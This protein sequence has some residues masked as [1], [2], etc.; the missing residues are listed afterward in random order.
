MTEVRAERFLP[1]FARAPVP[2]V[3]LDQRRRILAVNLAAEEAL[4][5]DQRRALGLT[6]QKMPGF[7]QSYPV[8]RKG[9]GVQVSQL[10]SEDGMR[11]VRLSHI[12]FRLQNRT[13]WLLIGEEL[14]QEKGL[15]ELTTLSHDLLSPLSTIKAYASTLL[16]LE[17]EISPEQKRDYLHS[18]ERVTS[19]L[20][21][22]VQ[23]VLEG[24][25]LE[26]GHFELHLKALSLPRLLRSIVM[27]M[28][29]E[30]P[31]HVIKL[32]KPPAMPLFFVDEKRLEM[33]LTNLITN[34]IKYSPQGSAIEVRLSYLRQKR[35]LR[36][37]ARKAPS[38]PPGPW[39]FIEV[40]DQGAGIPQEYL[41]SI[42]EPFVRASKGRNPA[43]GVG[44]GLYICK[45]IVEAHGG[46]TWARSREGKGSTFSVLL[47][48]QEA[49]DQ[50]V[51]FPSA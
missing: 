12:P 13:F 1:N 32:E 34:A 28:Q 38:L 45:K 20:A 2:L 24:S 37:E 41:E 47:P 21:R 22:L 39:A 42:F 16:K 17:G 5:L 3:V 49:G 25:S 11:K 10:S 43:P 31:H 27:Q 7:L 50:G 35:E 15:P 19:R 51:L 29:G 30:T 14:D 26:T 9:A 46:L 23:N 33:L 44:L 40:R 4:G 18:I 8:S 48:R 36:G 6:F